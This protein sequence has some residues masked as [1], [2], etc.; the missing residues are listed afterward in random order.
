ML[1]GLPT[2]RFVVVIAV[3]VVVVVDVRYRLQSLQ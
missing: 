1:E 2:S 3:V